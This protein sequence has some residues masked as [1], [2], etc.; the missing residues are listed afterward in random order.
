MTATSAL[1]PSITPADEALTAQQLAELTA[2]LRVE[3]AMLTEGSAFLARSDA[4][5]A[6]AQFGGE[7]R[8]RSEGDGDAAALEREMLA[9]LSAGSAASLADIDAALARLSAGTFGI[10]TRCGLDIPAARLMARP[11]AGTCVRCASAR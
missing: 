11:R 3:R 1:A 9:Q 6:A 8:P 7:T 5:L 4:E 10:C 2:Q